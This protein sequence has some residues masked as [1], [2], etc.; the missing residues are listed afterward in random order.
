MGFKLGSETRSPIARRGA[1]IK[2]DL[3]EGVLGQAMNDGS[4]VLDSS[5]KKGTEKY[6]IVK[7]HENQHAQDIKAGNLS[8][9]DLSVKW[10]GK[11]YPR[12][13]G[14]IFYNMKW[15]EEGHPELPW[16]AK[17]IKAEK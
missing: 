3:Q 10:H 4:V 15:Y 6:N 2:Q 9:T 11:N 1:V 14:K 5:L 13:Q 7:N 12:K 8:Y 16:E 17:A